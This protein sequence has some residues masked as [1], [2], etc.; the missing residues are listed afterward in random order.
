MQRDV[1]GIN[2]TIYTLYY[3]WA[4]YNLIADHFR[5]ALLPKE[6]AVRGA[7]ITLSAMLNDSAA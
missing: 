6:T 1:Q 2:Y 5:S 7:A 3:K 4:V